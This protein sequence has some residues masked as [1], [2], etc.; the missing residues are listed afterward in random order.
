[1]RKVFWICGL[2]GLTVLPAHGRE[3]LTVD[4]SPG[5]AFAPATMRIRARIEPS[6]TN[7][8]LTIV[9]DGPDFYRSSEVQLDGEQAPKTIEMQFSDIPGGEY[10]V[11]AVLS[12]TMGR[13]RA[14]AHRYA[15][16]MGLGSE[17]LSK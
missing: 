8:L 7:R 5:V 13:Q 11:S 10:D 4:V 9:A 17:S 15:K 12:D 6:P 3:P 1:M 14:N 16:V 2:I